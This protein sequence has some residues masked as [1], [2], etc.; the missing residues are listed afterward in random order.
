[1]HV[2]CSIQD[3]ETSM[4]SLIEARLHQSLILGQLE[5]KILAATVKLWLPSLLGNAFKIPKR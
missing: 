4:S 3:G 1:M 2:F 5:Y